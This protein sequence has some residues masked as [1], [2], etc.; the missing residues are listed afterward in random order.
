MQVSICV[1]DGM[2]ACSSRE[3]AHGKMRLRPGLFKRRC[4]NLVARLTIVDVCM[5]AV[6]ACLRRSLQNVGGFM[7]G[8]AVGAANLRVPFVL[9][10]CMGVHR[11]LVAVDE[12]DAVTCPINTRSSVVAA[13]AGVVLNCGAHELCGGLGIPDACM[14]GCQLRGVIMAVHAVSMAHRKNPCKQRRLLF[15]PR[16]N[17]TVRIRAPVSK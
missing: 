3:K 11:C 12:G 13:R 10:Q 1:P 8:M 4:A 7:C 2:R 17:G 9:R 15:S 16:G 6:L 5:V 14:D